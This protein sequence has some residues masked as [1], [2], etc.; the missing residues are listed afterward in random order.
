[1]QAFGALDEHL[2]GETGRTPHPGGRPL[3]REQGIRRRD[4]DIDGWFVRP[5]LARC[6]VAV[7]E[8]HLMGARSGHRQRNALVDT[9]QTGY[10][11]VG[12]GV[13][14]AFRR[15][16]RACDDS[17]VAV[18]LERGRTRL[19]ERGVGR[20]D[21]HERPGRAH[22]AARAARYAGAHV[23]VHLVRADV[24]GA[25]LAH[26]LAPPTCGVAVAHGGAAVAHDDD[27]ALLERL[28]DG[29][30]VVDARH[31]ISIRH[32]STC[33]K[34]IEHFGHVGFHALNR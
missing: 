17:A 15:D 21:G 10:L 12:G 2:L 3:C 34:A 32:E 27:R 16:A 1:M 28:G 11:G 29:D 31:A 7:D 19:R 20:F 9:R 24:D 22:R 26:L 8:Q 30:Y 14:L 18:G 4:R 25:L 5:V 6:A 23:Q 33:P 13:G